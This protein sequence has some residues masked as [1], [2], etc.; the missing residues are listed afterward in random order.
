ME[1]LP[2]RVV[3]GQAG[4]LERLVE[5][6]DRPPIH[7]VVLAVAGVEAD[8]K[9]LVA[10]R[11]GVGRRPAERLRPV[12]GQPLGVVGLEAVAERVTDD[13]VGENPGVPGLGE[14]QDP[15][16]ATRRLIHAAH[17]GRMPPTGLAGTR[18]AN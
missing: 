4:V 14:T 6:G 12:G 18:S 13:G 16:V 11:A 9:R 2:E 7:V 10:E 5:A 15:G 1:R 3:R 17:A 8:D